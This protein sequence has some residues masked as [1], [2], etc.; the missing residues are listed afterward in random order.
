MGV[1]GDGEGREGGGDAR[2]RGGGGG[3]VLGGDAGLWGWVEIDFF[4]VQGGRG[5]GDQW[6]GCGPGLFQG[7]DKFI[8]GSSELIDFL[9]KL[10]CPGRFRAR[11]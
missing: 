5:G 10:G 11:R 4:R 8:H 7:E 9:G 3:G 2:A 1:G 6:R